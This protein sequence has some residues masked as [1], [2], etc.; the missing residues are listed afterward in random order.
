MRPP[1]KTGAKGEKPAPACR[2]M[3]AANAKLQRLKV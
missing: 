3:T 2:D 1:N